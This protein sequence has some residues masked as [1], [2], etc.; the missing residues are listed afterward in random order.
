MSESAE[1][2]KSFYLI[3]SG[4]KIVDWKKEFVRV[5]IPTVHHHEFKIWASQDGKS[6]TFDLPSSQD[7]KF[8]GLP[9]PTLG[10][11]TPDSEGF[12]ID[13]EKITLILD[14][15]KPHAI[16]GNLPRPARIETLAGRFVKA[17]HFRNGMTA[18]HVH[19]PTSNFE[20]KIGDILAWRYDGLTKAPSLLIDGKTFHAAD[21]DKAYAMV[22]IGRLALGQTHDLRAGGG[23]NELMRYDTSKKTT[24]R[25]MEVT[26]EQTVFNY[27]K[28]SSLPEMVKAI[29]DPRELI[30]GGGGVGSC[31]EVNDR[32]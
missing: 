23:A 15:P 8:E 24:F 3:W 32:G 21:L 22:I 1:A 13:G 30:L 4:H 18:D 26:E 12:F 5:I 2:A 29:L 27:I 7:A 25:L 31:D 9:T 11:R 14:D 10:Y 19:S 6:K 20:Y 16:L 17:E 28:S